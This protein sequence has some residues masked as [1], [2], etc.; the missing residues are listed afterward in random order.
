MKL[1]V[2]FPGWVLQNW[3]DS[4]YARVPMS[5]EEWSREHGFALTMLV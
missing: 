1:K 2:F 3:K 4:K 5:E